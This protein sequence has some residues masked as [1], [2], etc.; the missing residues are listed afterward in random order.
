MIDERKKKANR[1]AQV[2]WRMHQKLGY[3]YWDKLIAEGFT[4]DQI[5]EFGVE[6][7]VKAKKLEEMKR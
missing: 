6:Y 5:V 7:F 1:E 4:P 2:R 3:G